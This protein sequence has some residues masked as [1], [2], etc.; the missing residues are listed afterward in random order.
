MLVATVSI[1]KETKTESTRW[2][3][4]FGLK[5][6]V[7][8]STEKKVL[9]YDI[10]EQKLRRATTK[11]DL[12]SMKN[13]LRKMTRLRRKGID[14]VPKLEGAEL[15]PLHVAA[16]QGDEAT[17]ELL[18]EFGYDINSK[19]LGLTPLHLATEHSH[20]D[21][22]ELLAASKADLNIADDRHDSAALHLAARN[23]IEKGTQSLLH[24]GANPEVRDR[25]SMSPLQVATL[26]GQLKTVEILLRHG[27]D[28][29]SKATYGHNAFQLETQK[30]LSSFSRLALTLRPSYL[31][32]TPHS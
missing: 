27:V 15:T 14:H 9:G 4:I 10:L 3:I 29:A 21:I 11:G 12:T 24:H 17:A 2:L 5:D 1:S 28:I 31:T 30:L 18:I 16:W 19:P 23:G 6:D 25:L 20:E 32:S 13:W 8:E 26:A 7:G 22:I